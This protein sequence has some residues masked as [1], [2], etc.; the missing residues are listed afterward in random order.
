MRT[1]APHQAGHPPVVG[2]PA[3][4]HEVVADRAV[5]AGHGGDPEVHVGRE[6]AVE[7]DLPAADALAHARIGEVE[8]AQV[9]GLLE[10]PRPVPGEEDR[11]AVRSRTA[12][13]G[14]VSVMPPTLAGAWAGGKARL[15]LP[16]VPLDPAAQPVT[17]VP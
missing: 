14:S 2:H 17:L 3:H 12:A 16:A 6:P 4:R 15:V 13:H 10:F 7:L 11:A 1:P 5:R 9:H 8:E